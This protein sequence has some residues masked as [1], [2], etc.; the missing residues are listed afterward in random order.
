MDEQEDIDILIKE[1][2]YFVAGKDIIDVGCGKK[3]P[4]TIIKIAKDGDAK[5]Y[6]GIDSNN[7]PLHLLTKTEQEEATEQGEEDMLIAVGTK[8]KIP[9]ILIKGD[10]LFVLSKMEKTGNKF[11][12]FAGLDAYGDATEYFKYLVVELN[13]LCSFED[14][15]L[16][17]GED[18]S[19]VNELLLGG[20]KRK[21]R[22]RT[23]DLFVKN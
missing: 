1:H 20:F 16:L 3:G 22:D 7:L 5:R 10:M 15:I 21:I 9:L 19:F 14:A 23:F 6:I 12:V 13:R 2:G 11:F 18:S 17:I 4:K 8:D